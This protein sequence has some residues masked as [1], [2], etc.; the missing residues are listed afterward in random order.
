M[1]GARAHKQLRRWTVPPSSAQMWMVAR[2]GAK[3]S[4]LLQRVKASIGL[5]MDARGVLVLVGMDW[6]LVLP[7]NGVGWLVG[8]SQTRDTLPGTTGKQREKREKET[9]QRQS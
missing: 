3:V 6:C 7:S 9:E 1:R 4:N 2:L 8:P 5:T